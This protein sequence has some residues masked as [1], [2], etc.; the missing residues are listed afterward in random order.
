MKVEQASIFEVPQRTELSRYVY[1]GS[2]KKTLLFSNAWIYFC[3]LHIL[4]I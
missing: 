3:G 2:T 4:I 1:I